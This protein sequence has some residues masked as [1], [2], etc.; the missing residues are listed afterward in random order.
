MAGLDTECGWPVYS[1]LY[2]WIQSTVGLDTVYCRR[3]Y[4]LQYAWIQ[5]TVGLYT[6]YSR[7]GCSLKEALIQVLVY[8]KTVGLDLFYIVGLD[9]G[10]CIIAFS[11]MMRFPIPSSDPN[12]VRVGG[13]RAHM[14]YAWSIPSPDPNCIWC[15]FEVVRL[16]NGPKGGSTLYWYAEPLTLTPTPCRPYACNLSVLPGADT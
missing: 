12:S 7:H 6:V 4:G 10:P 1:L 13:Y 15:S 9:V 16:I 11:A 2:A 14:G 8:T 5:S 3:V